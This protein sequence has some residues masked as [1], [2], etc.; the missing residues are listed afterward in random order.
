MD[1]MHLKLETSTMNGNL[2]VT[3]TVPNLSD[4]LAKQLSN[5]L[6]KNLN[7][8]YPSMEHSLSVKHGPTRINPCVGHDFAVDTA[9]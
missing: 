4:E 8:A 5:W 2:T 7:W 1:G 9:P 6:E 3:M